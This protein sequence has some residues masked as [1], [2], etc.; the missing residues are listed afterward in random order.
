MEK[1]AALMDVKQYQCLTCLPQQQKYADGNVVENQMP[2]QSNRRNSWMGNILRATTM[3]GTK[4][5][6]PPTK[7]QIK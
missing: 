3:G 6:R 1:F 2:Y 4:V 5:G 7:K